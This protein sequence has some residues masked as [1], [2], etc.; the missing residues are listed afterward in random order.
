M[1]FLRNDGSQEDCAMLPILYQTISAVTMPSWPCGTVTI[2]KTYKSL[3]Y[4]KTTFTQSHPN[5]MSLHTI[6]KPILSPHPAIVGLKNPQRQ[7]RQSFIIRFLTFTFLETSFLFLGA[8]CL[9]HPIQLP[10]SIANGILIQDAKAI[11]TAISVLWHALA[12]LVAKDIILQV[13]SAE[14][15]A[16]YCYMGTLQPNQTD[17]MSVITS[18]LLD[19]LKHAILQKSTPHF[20]LSLAIT[21]VLLGLGPLGASTLG[22][23]LLWVDTI[24]EIQV[25]NI[26]IDYQDASF[27]EALERA[28]RIAKSEMLDHLPIGYNISS[29]DTLIPWPHSSFSNHQGVIKYMS[30]IALY[31]YSCNWLYPTFLDIQ[32][33]TLGSGPETIT[34]V[35]VQNTTWSG[36]GLGI[37]WFCEDCGPGKLVLSILA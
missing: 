29:Q 37:L 26:T 6:Y 24:Q 14:W 5:Q 35:N 34:T 21:L 11:T 20:R 12:G 33:L 30:D 28:G 13:F 8:W 16:L 27:S 23:N 7:N 31:N 17:A 22:I 36:D 25:A 19:Q 18:G 2:I 1:V 4:A 15:A 10:I 32:N 9:T 3:Q